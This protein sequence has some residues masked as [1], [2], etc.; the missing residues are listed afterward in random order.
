MSRRP[1]FS[2]E[3]LRALEN[4]HWPGNVRELQNAVEQAVW[5]SGTGGTVEVCH[6]PQWIQG[7]SRLVPV[8]ER[9]RDVADDLFDTL[10]K[11]NYTFWEHIYPLFLARELTRHDVRALVRRGLQATGGNF[12]PLLKLFG[13]PSRDYKR[14]LNF[15]STHGCTVDYRSIRNGSRNLA[16]RNNA[17]VPEDP[18]ARAARCSAPGSAVYL[19][20][21][22]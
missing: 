8:R 12:R 4:H 7:A 21:S 19:D 11:N 14:F 13:I 1:T 2:E 22:R 5:M 9:R 16:L 15:L 6:L 10:T 17:V 20:R 18:A 3:A